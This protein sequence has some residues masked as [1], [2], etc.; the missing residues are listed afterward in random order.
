MNGGIQLAVEVSFIL[1]A[2]ED[3]TRLVR[4]IGEFVGNN[5]MSRVEVK[6]YYGNP[7]QIFSVL[8]NQDVG[9][10]VLGKILK[11]FSDNDMEVILASL[12][13]SIDKNGNLHMRLDKQSILERKIR[14]SKRDP[15]KLK[16]MP[17]VSPPNPSDWPK[18][19]SKKLKELRNSDQT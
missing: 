13:S 10:A 5:E 16:V 12:N 2:M 6:G 18:W 7:M 1:N 17:R 11:L 8:L 15:L 19:Y 9:E 3:E 14:L 4:Q